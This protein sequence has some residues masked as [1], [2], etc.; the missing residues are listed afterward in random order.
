MRLS[1]WLAL[2]LLV[3]LTGCSNYPYPVAGTKAD[4]SAKKIWYQT[5]QEDPRSFDPQVTYDTVSEEILANITE[6]L[7]QYN[8]LK[9]N[10]FELIPALADGMPVRTSRPGGGE[11]WTL[12]LKRGLLFQDDP[13][14][15]A[16]K[17]REVT[18]DDFI[19]AIKR[20]GDPF[21]KAPTAPPLYETLAQVILGLEDFYHAAQKA[22]KADY[23]QPLTGAER[24][25]RYT[26]KIH[27]TRPYPQLRYWLALRFFA[28]VPPEA[29]AY[30]DGQVHNGTE[31]DPF[32]FHPVGTG[33]YKLKSW[34]R[35][36]RLVLVRNENYRARDHYP[37]EGDPGDREKGLLRDAGKPL[38]FVDEAY[39][40]ITR[41]SIP[42]WTLF[43]QG[44]VDHIGRMGRRLGDNVAQA[45]TASG[46]LSPDFEKNG[47]KLERIVNLSTDYLGFNMTD[48]VVGNSGP[49]P[50]RNKKLR[51]AISTAY[52]FDRFN[53]YFYFGVKVKAENLLPPGMFGYDVGY[54][55]PYRTQ[56]V[57][58]GKQLMREAGYPDGVDPKTGRPLTLEL[59][60]QAKGPESQRE[61]QYFIE[62]FGKLG[63][64]L[65]VKLVTWSEMQNI[66]KKGNYQITRYGW[67]ADYPDAENF[68]F[69]LYSKSSTDLNIT[70]YK[71]PEFDR[72]YEKMIVMED[73]PERLGLIKRMQDILAE[74]CP[75]L[76]T[77][78][79]SYYILNQGW[80]NNVLIHPVAYNLLKYYNV[81]PAL[82][83]Q[84][85]RAWNQPNYGFVL[86]LAGL[87][88]AAILPVALA[89][90][91]PL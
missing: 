75:W 83:E 36:Q 25:D 61:A 86:A 5:L 73:T 47:V 82:R 70:R 32:M 4:G 22:G 17:G 91:D 40:T 21:I 48:A 12:K 69:L 90:K 42:M 88:T 39:Y 80:T 60:Y 1:Q 64:K 7:Y 57:Q 30:W 44:Y 66:T 78:Y 34:E 18:S 9:R 53:D 54:K 10:K 52:D 2:G 3:L 11:T 23:S 63:I 27:L 55:N 19:Y 14:F 59:V 50:E 68:F 8:Y 71:N 49:S 58:K 89:R 43:R 26:F 84:K 28:P 65:K 79:E 20:H 31:R 41:E 35:N 62:E 46:A 81:D 76:F 38:P 33:A 77:F 87:L 51:Q 13:C 85:E 74:D 56:D 37:S 29:V 72:L 6:Q 67:F 16:G 45:V 24:V 15:E